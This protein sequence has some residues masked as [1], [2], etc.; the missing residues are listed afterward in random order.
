MD[1]DRG[2]VDHLRIDVASRGKG[3]E[4]PVPDA[5]FRHRTKRL[6]QIA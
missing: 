5:D 3:V 1:P 6:E 2:S 4:N